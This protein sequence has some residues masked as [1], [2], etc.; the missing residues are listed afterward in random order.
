MNPVPDGY[1]ECDACEKNVPKDNA[2]WMDECGW[3]CEECRYVKHYHARGA[4]KNRG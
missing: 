1:V 2:Q 3:V 4:E